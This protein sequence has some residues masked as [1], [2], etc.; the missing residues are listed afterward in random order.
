MHF[1]GI[2]YRFWSSTPWLLI[3]NQSDYKP[4]PLIPC[5]V[6]S[7]ETA[8]WNKTNLYHHGTSDIVENTAIVQVIKRGLLEYKRR[9]LSEHITEGLHLGCGEERPAWGIEISVEK[10]EDYVGVDMRKHG[11]LK[12]LKDV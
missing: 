10:N 3:R 11:K 6:L 4:R 5:Q 1:N 9:V 8:M 12:G 7:D 2:K